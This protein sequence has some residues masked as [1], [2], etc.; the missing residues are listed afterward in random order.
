MRVVKVLL[1]AVLILS[2]AALYA[3][4][5]STYKNDTSGLAISAGYGYEFAGFGGQAAYYLKPSS[6]ISVVPYVSGGYFY[7]SN[8]SRP[9]YAFGSLF[10][11]GDRHRFVLDFGYGLAAIEYKHRVIT[12]ETY[13]VRTLYGVTA[14][15]GWE[16]MTRKG[17]FIRLTIGATYYTDKPKDDSESRYT[18]TINAAIGYKFF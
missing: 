3:E 5:G 4:D 14:A 13:D 16:L 2:G 1:T 18:P 17:L 15:A 11:F 10:E 8:E 9:G 6:I 12:D 7:D